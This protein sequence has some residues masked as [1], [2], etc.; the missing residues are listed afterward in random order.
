M[1]LGGLWH[2]ASWTFVV[3]GVPARPLP[4]VHRAFRAFCERRPRLDGLLRTPPGTS[5][6]A[7]RRPS[8]PSRLLWVFFRATTFGGAALML[9]RLVVP[10][11]GLPCPLDVGV[12][13]AL[14]GTTV[15]CV[16]TGRRVEGPGPAVAGPGAGVRLRGG[17]GPRAAADAG[18]V[19]PGVHL[20]PILDG[21]RGR[22]MFR[23]SPS[24]TGVRAADAPRSCGASPRFS[25]R[26][27]GWTWR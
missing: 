24:C 18:R 9:H 20:L 15:T 25:S 4:V 17:D 14:A 2:G 13:W 12:F 11:A 23:S 8:W 7:S 3:W 1:T 21:I 26:S 10:H 6:S 16:G 5:R 27:W 19:Q 22:L